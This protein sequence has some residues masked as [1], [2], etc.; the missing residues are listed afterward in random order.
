MRKTVGAQA[1]QAKSSSTV[2]VETAAHVAVT[3]EDAA[4]P[5]E[6]AFDGRGGP[7]STEWIAGAPG[8][9]TITVSFDSPEA[10]RAV[11]LEIEETR[12][13][14]TQQVEL[15]VATGDGPLAFVLR[16]EFTFSPSG[17][18]LGREHWA[19]DRKDVRQV[20][21]VIRPD[22]GGGSSRARVTTLAF[23]R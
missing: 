6:H 14:R 18:T 19:I 21:L 5:I 2:D 4:H 12:E 17:A 9:Q 15:A 8:D 3:S 13:G 20:R 10:L 22:K 23:E 11:V 7:G 1:A 16:Q